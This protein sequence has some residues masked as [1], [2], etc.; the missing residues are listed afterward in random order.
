MA[1]LQMMQRH[2]GQDNLAKEKSFRYGRSQFNQRI[3]AF[4]SHFSKSFV[5]FW[6]DMIQVEKDN[7]FIY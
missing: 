5:S 1:T 7:I 4:W 2:D 6:S 3:E